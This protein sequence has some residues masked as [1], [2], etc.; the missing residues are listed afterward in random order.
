MAATDSLPSDGMIPELNDSTVND[1]LA[2]YP[3]FILDV[4]E[5]LCNPCQRMKAAIFELSLELSGQ[6]AFGMIDGKKNQ[7]TDRGYNISSYPT[8]L[9]FENGTLVD[10]RE[11][12]AS[13]RYIVDG[14]R[15]V[16]PDLNTSRVT[17]G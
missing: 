15:R 10:R 5:P 2:M 8:L 4:Y 14:L 13:K 9:V 7:K 3:F 11:G 1:T 6:A 17:Y 12:F 16:K